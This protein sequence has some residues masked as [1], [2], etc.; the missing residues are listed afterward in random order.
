MER[1]KFVEE[2][3]ACQE[4]GQGYKKSPAWKGDERTA[5]WGGGAVGG[6]VGICKHYSLFE[7]WEAYISVLVIRHSIGWKPKGALKRTTI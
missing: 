1:A 7:L 4:N 5:P 6:H 2:M 3:A